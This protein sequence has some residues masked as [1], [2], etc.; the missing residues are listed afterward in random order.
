MTSD[1]TFLITGSNGGLG[2]GVVK[3]LLS[4]GYKKVACHYRSENN[5]VS[6]IL[7]EFGLSANSN[8]F[9]ADLCDEAS[10]A[11]L[12]KS[13]ERSIGRVD[14][15]VNLAGG[16]TNSM[17]WKLTKDQF[18]GSINDNLVS[19]FMVCK[20]FIP[21]MRESKGGR[22]INTSS[23]VGFTGVAGASHYCA[24]KAGIA[25]FSKALSLELANKAITVNTLALGYFDTGLI[26]DVPPEL[27][28]TIK[29]TI[30]IKRFGRPN[31]VGALIEYL[32]GDEASYL[33]GQTLHLNGGLY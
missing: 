16:S 8:A 10:V 21:S 9:Q 13:I 11:S 20:E 33:T 27:Q 5:V 29:S 12:R 31:E 14:V 3:Y 2:S 15:L 24:A 28:E 17:S 19:T 30:P 23:V 26:H 1:K 4:K 22:I 7:S 6:S 32:S 25:G 18:M